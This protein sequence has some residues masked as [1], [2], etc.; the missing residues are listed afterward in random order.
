MWSIFQEYQ[1]EY[2]EEGSVYYDYPYLPE[3]QQQQYSEE[4]VHVHEHDHDH[5][6]WSQP[7][8][9]YLSNDYSSG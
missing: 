1:Q 8:L 9:N 6:H 2:Q 7:E 5:G 3:Q 4:P